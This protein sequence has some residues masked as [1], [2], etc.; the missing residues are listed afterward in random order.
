[1][2]AD[3][4]VASIEEAVADVQSGARIMVGGFGEAG[5]PHELVRALAAR[6]LRDLTIISNNADF[7]VLAERG[8]LSRLACSYPVGPTAAPVRA[9][10][11]SGDIEL[12]II[13][14]GTLVE[15]IRAGGS[16]LGGVLTPTGVG[17]VFAE[18]YRQIEHDGRDYLLAPAM[19]ADFAF[20]KATVGDRRGNLYY[21]HA[22]RNFNPLMATAA[23][24][25]V[26]QV[27]S[28]VEVGDMDPDRIHTPSPFVGRIVHVPAKVAA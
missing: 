28:L 27:T 11:E 14:Q 17:A 2:S 13:P 23:D 9:A 1:M 20:V 19:R 15:R 8:C 4:V 21:R 25:T 3:K 18:G 22:S 5:F 12:E 26:A 7:G 16:G 6:E 24:V 10:I